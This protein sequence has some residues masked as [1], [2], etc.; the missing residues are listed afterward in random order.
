MRLKGKT[1]LITGAGNGIG[2]TTALR[3]AAEGAEVAVADIREQAAAETAR[4]IERAGGKALPIRMDISQ[5][6]DWQH[7]VN[8]VVA[9]FG[10]IDV[11]FNNAAIFLIKP[12]IE[13]TVEDWD[14][15]M[16]VNVRGTFLGLKHVIP[17]M[18]KQGGG[19]IINNASTAGLVGAKGVALYGSS[20]G[21]IRNLSKHAA[22]EYA[23][24][25]VR[26]NSIYPGFVDTAML[27]HR[28]DTEQNNSAEQGKKVPLGR[29]GE[30]REI[31]DTV[32]FL[33]SDESS[34]ITGA[35]IVIDGGRT[36]GHLR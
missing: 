2:K 28:M 31:A 17:V 23:E 4:E 29:I 5:E 14:R 16:G 11:L 26:V 25:G 30:P 19:S 22:L 34:Y 18:I 6:A 33:A 7:A 20:K 15:I 27:K 32:V 21:A 35:E 1:A 9:R 36:A 3:F 24:Y 13:T 12:L 8:Q 10:Q